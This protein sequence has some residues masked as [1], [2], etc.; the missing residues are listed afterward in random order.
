M[1]KLREFPRQAGQQLGQGEQ[2]LD[3]ASNFWIEQ[4]IAD[5]KVNVMMNPISHHIKIEIWKPVI[6]LLRHE[7][8]PD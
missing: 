2:L 1:E 3:E 5:L 6:T 8:W 7:K 4:L